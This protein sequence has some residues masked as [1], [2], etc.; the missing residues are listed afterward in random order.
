MPKRTNKKVREEQIEYTEKILQP[1][2][3]AANPPKT[4]EATEENAAELESNISVPP[5]ARKEKFG[6]FFK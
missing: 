4:K 1:E 3:L 5:S 6:R 2:I